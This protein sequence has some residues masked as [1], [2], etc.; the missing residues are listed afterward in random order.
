MIIDNVADELLARLA[1]IEGLKTHKGMPGT[2][3]VP[4]AVLPLP[5]RI[6]YQGAYRRGMNRITW[7]LL[8][9]VT[10]VTDRL[11]LPRLSA[12][13]SSSAEV[14]VPRV[15]ETGTYTA[16]DVVT[17]LSA[18]TDV[19]TWGAVDYA[20]VLFELDIVGPGS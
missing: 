11:V 9:L 6:Q 16:F 4:A 15:L 10:K 12:Y 13:A 7:P 17:V 8:V 1:G 18:E 3:T 5:E 2:L 14:N 19:V 20:A